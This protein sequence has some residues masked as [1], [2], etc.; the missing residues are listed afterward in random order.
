M[1]EHHDAT[2]TR[3]CPGCEHIDR[4]L[5]EVRHVLREDPTGQSGAEGTL[6]CGRC[7]RVHGIHE[8]AG[9]SAP[10]RED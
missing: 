10:T 2:G 4:V 8:H 1:S 3:A 6:G 5:A 7:G 9:T